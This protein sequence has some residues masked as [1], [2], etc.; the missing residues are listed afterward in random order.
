MTGISRLGRLPMGPSGVYV[1]NTTDRNTNQLSNDYLSGYT[2]RVRWNKIEIGPGVYDWALIDQVLPQTQA[3]RQKVTLEIFARDVPAHVMADLSEAT[4]ADQRGF[5][6]CVPWDS[7]AQTAWQAFIEV[8]ADHQTPIATDVGTVRL[9]DHPALLTI[10]APLLGTQSVRD[11]LQTLVARPDYTRTTF[12]DACEFA[13]QVIRDNFP[14]QY[15]FVGVFPMYDSTVEPRLD[16]AVVDRL[17]RVFVPI[18]TRD[19]K[20]GFFQ[21][22][23]TDSGPTTEVIGTPLLRAMSRTWVMFQALTNWS[24]P[25]TGQDKVAS[26]DPGVGATFANSTYRCRYVEL[27]AKD[28]QNP[29]LQASLSDAASLLTSGAYPILEQTWPSVTITEPD[30]AELVAGTITITAAVTAPPGR[31]ITQVKFIVAGITI[32][33]DTVA[34]WGYSWDTTAFIDGDY[35]MEVRATD[36]AGN[37]GSGF[38]N[39]ILRNGNFNPYVEILEPEADTGVTGIVNI[40]AYATGFSAIT[41]VEIL[42]D[43]G[44]KKVDMS[45]PYTYSWDSSTVLPGLHTISAKATDAD[46]RQTTKDILVYVLNT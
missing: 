3:R 43:G 11:I 4:W 46:G 27:Y 8:L 5:V 30:E 7:N 37:I 34:P 32:Q 28:I 42:V 16:L 18:G 25:W 21:E 6:T 15:T 12:I 1:M 14:A 9:A 17:L 2:L 10:D 20:L 35:G 41:Q 26:G 19:P 23:L 33:T 24:T 22:L 13:V 39:F 44:S 38:R 45:S 31:T 29:A 40:S 36:S